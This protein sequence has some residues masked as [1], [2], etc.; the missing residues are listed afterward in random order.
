MTKSDR[1]FI[2][3]LSV[4]AFQLSLPLWLEKSA[5]RAGIAMCCLYIIVLL[6]VLDVA[7]KEQ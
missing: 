7:R 5:E 3:A 4:L 2:T 6:M 1:L